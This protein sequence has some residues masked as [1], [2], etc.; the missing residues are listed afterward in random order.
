MKKIGLLLVLFTVISCTEKTTASLLNGY[1]EIK[2]VKLPGGKQKQFEASATV[3]YFE[4]E[5]NKGFRKKVMPQFDGSYRAS[6][7][8]EA[9]TLVEK[10]GKTWLDHKALNSKYREELISVSSEELV[11]KN[12]FGMEFHYIKPENFTVK[13]DGKT[14]E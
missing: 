13:E 5:G 14:A 8:S 11:L 3:D 4:F 1:W 7:S 6:D 12:S 9:V 10:D 2:T